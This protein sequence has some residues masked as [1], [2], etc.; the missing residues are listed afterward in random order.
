MRLATAP[1]ARSASGHPAPGASKA[2]ESAS[3]RSLVRTFAAG[4]RS[5]PPPPRGAFDADAAAPMR[6]LSQAFLTPPRKKSRDRFWNFQK[7]P[8]SLRSSQTRRSGSGDRRWR[9]DH[10]AWCARPARRHA[11]RVVLKG[12]YAKHKKRASGIVGPSSTGTPSTALTT[13]CPGASSPRQRA[14]HRASAWRLRSGRAPS[15]R[16]GCYGG[17]TRRAASRWSATASGWRGRHRQRGGPR[18][19]AGRPGVR[20]FAWFRRGP[21]RNR[22]NPNTC[23]PLA[24]TTISIA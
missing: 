6:P 21:L 1:D 13:S 24:V 18:A 3:V 8:C 14:P 10:R 2:P 5:R 17:S 7:I 19:D 15:A 23:Q 12:V 16:A 4:G 11:M 22:A 9:G 20:G